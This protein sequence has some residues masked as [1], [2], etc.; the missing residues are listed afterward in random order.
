MFTLAALAFCLTAPP[1]N[2]R[3]VRGQELVY[4][5]QCVEAV[6][7]DIAGPR[8]T[9][10]L[11]TRLF[12]LETDSEL[13]VATTVTDKDDSA[14]T[15][16]GIAKPG[17]PTMALTLDRPATLD[18]VVF[19][20]LP[21]QP[22]EVGATWATNDGHR[23]PRGWKVEAAESPPQGGG[24]CWKLRGLQQ[25]NNWDAPDEAKAW[26]RE[27]VA[28]VD[29][30]TLIV[31][32]LERVVTVRDPSQSDAIRRIITCYQLEGNMVYPGQLDAEVRAEILVARQAFDKLADR[33]D[34]RWL[35]TQSRRLA[36]H[37]RTQPKT[38]WRYV[39]LA[40][41]KQVEAARRGE[42]VAVAAEEEAQPDWII[43]RPSPDFV[44]SI[45]RSKSI[46]LIDCHGKPTI[47]CVFRSFEPLGIDAHDALR[48]LCSEVQD[49]AVI[50]AVDNTNACGIGAM[51]PDPIVSRKATDRMPYGLINCCNGGRIPSLQDG[52]TPRF[53]LIDER[54]IVR[55]IIDGY[56]SEVPS[57][58]RQF[59][60][61]AGPVKA[62]GHDEFDGRK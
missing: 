12:V 49:K 32:R 2:A 57:L 53:I 42:I 10:D 33:P 16:F 61:S 20:D 13:A 41:E 28:W 21:Y 54:G 34:A 18:P 62:A 43:G 4:R 17:S 47:I 60:E 22:L 1:E 44:V 25:T 56:G 50:V 30:R 52:P 48:G 8:R 9:F 15:R 38:E 39:V 45:G 7:G 11:V 3:Y 35:D 27:D 55:Q 59:V 29:T 14:A 26:R 19:F 6:T 5:G 24:R 40:A 31:Q 23:P 36:S 58:L 46:R 37:T 51:I